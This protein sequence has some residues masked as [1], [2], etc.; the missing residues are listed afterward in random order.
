MKNIIKVFAVI[1]LVAG[2]TTT[3]KAQ[4]TLAGN[5]AGA[6]LV[7][8]L[9]IINTNPLTG[10]NFGR[11]GITTG[12]TGTVTMTTAGVCSSPATTTTIISGGPVTRSVPRFDLAGTPDVTYTITLPPTIH[13]TYG[14]SNPG[15]NSMDINALK[16]SVDG[17][18]DCDATSA[19]CKLNGGASHF[20]IGGTLNIV[21][22]Q[23][24]GVYA[25]SYSV[26]VDYN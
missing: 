4:V 14:G 10:F 24:I 3:H 6:E 8:V 22:D 13:V 25:G 11:I 18:A 9:T 21:G 1:F 19:M 12:A 5:L 2:I 15:T 17:A 7:K 20:L 23:A 16:V 26:T